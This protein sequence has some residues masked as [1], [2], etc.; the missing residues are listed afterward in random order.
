MEIL[1]K[2]L[3]FG[4]VVITTGLFTAAGVSGL[5]G[6]FFLLIIV[7]MISTLTRWLLRRLD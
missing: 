1:I 3:G 5:D 2:V 6:F 7:I 4:I